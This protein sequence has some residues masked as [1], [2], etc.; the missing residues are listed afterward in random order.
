[1]ENSFQK[2]K[3]EVCSFGDCLLEGQVTMF[4]VYD[5][6]IDA[7]TALKLEFES[8]SNIILLQ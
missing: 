2:S 3:T 1:M 7:K 4:V 8:S 5:W 6:E